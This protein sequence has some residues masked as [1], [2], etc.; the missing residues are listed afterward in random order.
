[1]LCA[2]DK[3]RFKTRL[4][5]KRL[6]YAKTEYCMK[7][8]CLNRYRA[9][10]RN[11]PTS[12][13]FGRFAMCLLTL[14]SCAISQRNLNSPNDAKQSNQ[15]EDSHMRRSVIPLQST[16]FLYHIFKN[17]HTL[18][19]LDTTELIHTHEILSCCTPSS[20]FLRRLITF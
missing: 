6:L 4:G 16:V 7:Y 1:M 5:F 13:Q 11:V 18:G 15:E 17:M 19:L 2:F 14:F 3:Q 12:P 9:L 8:H 10:I 20:P